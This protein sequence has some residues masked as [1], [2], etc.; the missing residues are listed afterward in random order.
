MCVS[1]AYS[2]VH[3]HGTLVHGKALLQQ[4]SLSNAICA[5][6]IHSGHG[7]VCIFAPTSNVV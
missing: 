1:T 4:S 2:N 5:H 6:L 7:F 3:I